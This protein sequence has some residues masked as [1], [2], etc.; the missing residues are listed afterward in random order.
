MYSGD[1][2]INLGDGKP[3]HSVLD[4]WRWAHNTLDDR[5]ERGVFAEYLVYTAVSDRAGKR[6]DGPYDLIGCNGLKI[7]VKSVAVSYKDDKLG[8]DTKSTFNISPVQIWNGWTRTFSKEK[9][10][11]S[12]IYVF[13]VW[14]DAGNRDSIIDSNSWEFYVMATSFVN[15]TF[16]TDSKSVSL[17]RI[18]K[19]RTPCCYSDLYKAVYKEYCEHSCLT[20]S[21]PDDPETKNTSGVD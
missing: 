9:I 4:F 17:S 10:R 14:T 3:V 15:E 16:G 8:N 6:Y 2:T 20:F 13:A 5:F 1:E 21:N 7:E 18:K 12:D 19:H 11:P